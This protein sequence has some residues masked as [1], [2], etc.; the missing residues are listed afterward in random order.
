MIT[1]S[2]LHSPSWAHS[3][4]H[5]KKYHLQ[6]YKR[7]SL[8][9]DPTPGIHTLLG[10]RRIGKSTQFK[11]WIQELLNSN[12]VAGKDVVYLDAERFE[13]WKELY[14]AI[15]PFEKC[16]LFIDEVTAP[17]DWERALKIFADE[18]KIE[19]AC[20]WITGSN[21]FALKHSGELLPGRRGK[22][23]VLR[24]VELLPLSFKEFYHALNA[25]VP[26]SAPSQS[27]E[28]FLRWGGYP[29]S[30][31]ECLTR[32]SCSTDW[33]Q[34]LL[35]VVLGEASRKHRSPRLTAALSERIWIN[36]TQK[37]SYHAISKMVDAGS[38]PIIRQ[39]I[40]IL[41]GCYTLLTEERFNPKTKGGI[42]KKEK[43]FYF[44]D[45]LVMHALVS[46]AQQGRLNPDWLK[47]QIEE[48]SKKGLLVENVVASELRKKNFV[49]Y[50]DEAHG[51]EI[52][53]VLPFQADLPAVEVKL[54]MPS[55]S[56]VRPITTYPRG[57]VWVY[58]WNE[59]NQKTIEIG[60]TRI[61]SLV[62]RLLEL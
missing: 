20:V 45:P 5:L 50:Y 44:L 40:E 11:L 33:L 6:P 24:D 29:T 27:F 32:E 55:L 47:A 19:E 37:T 35:D 38:H 54:S 25:K 7:A 22:G 8:V 48:P 53:F 13:N 61:C 31:S 34:E 57:E 60:G 43:K 56:E 59:P 39:Y 4:P 10:P 12:Q 46:Y 41:E 28:K 2:W 30:V 14:Q 15:A 49:F 23:L 16:I 9:F 17:Q 1:Q 18:G 51:G 42:L 26:E 52:D 36:L 58:R 21:A 62:E 3:D